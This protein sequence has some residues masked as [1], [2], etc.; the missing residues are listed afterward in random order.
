MLTATVNR[1]RR[2]M[3]M[4]WSDAPDA[5]AAGHLVEVAVDPVEPVQ[6]LQEDVVLDFEVRHQRPHLLLGLDVHLVIVLRAQAVAVG[7]AVEGHERDRDPQSRLQAHH[8]VEELEGI[9]VPVVDQGE[10]VEDHPG[11]RQ[12]DLDQDEGPAPDQACEIL[13]DAL[14]RRQAA[15]RLPVQI[16]HR[17]VVVLVADQLPLNVLDLSRRAHR[18]IACG[19]SAPAGYEK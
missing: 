12:N 18:R 13:P 11:Q 17:R 16:P 10:R 15:V 2:K 4:R 5:H 9:G 6:D 14:G 3:K 19:K 8:Q 7:Q 1:W